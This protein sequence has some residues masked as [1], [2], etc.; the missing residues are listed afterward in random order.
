[1]ARNNNDGATDAAAILAECRRH[2]YGAK[3]CGK[4]GF[5]ITSDGSAKPQFW[6]LTLKDG[7]L[8]DA[9]C[10]ADLPSKKDR[11]GLD[12]VCVMPQSHWNQLGDTVDTEFPRV[13]EQL[14][15]GFSGHLSFFIRHLEQLL[16]LIVTFSRAVSP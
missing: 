9:V 10:K 3:I 2:P 15:P 11:R 6:I 7:Q 12:L 5:V 13:L 1:M 8:T 16:K 14:E 4:C